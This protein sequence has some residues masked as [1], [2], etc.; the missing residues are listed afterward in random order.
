MSSLSVKLLHTQGGQLF[1]AFSAN[2]RWSI[3]SRPCRRNLSVRVLSRTQCPRLARC[4]VWRN[5]NAFC[6]H[7][8]AHAFASPLKGTKCSHFMQVPGYSDRRMDFDDRGLTLRIVTEGFLQVVW[9]AQ[10]LQLVGISDISEVQFWEV[11]WGFDQ[12]PSHSAPAPY[13]HYEGEQGW[14]VP[15]Y[16]VLL[17]T[18]RLRLPMQNPSESSSGIVSVDVG[19]FWGTWHSWLAGPSVPS[20][21]SGPGLLVTGWKLSLVQFGAVVGWSL[22]PFHPEM[23]RSDSWWGRQLHGQPCS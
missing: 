4:N 16:P 18:P 19:W 11:L 5:A 14:R 3:C 9:M 21:P 23:I 20:V 6:L 15:E 8:C 10:S 12:S 17:A 22:F 2:G 1:G 13:W 7:R